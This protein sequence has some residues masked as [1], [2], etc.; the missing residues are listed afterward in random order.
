MFGAASASALLRPRRCLG[1]GAASASMF[2]HCLRLSGE[3]WA[4]LVIIVQTM[5][6][7][8][9]RHRIQ[10]YRQCLHQAQQISLGG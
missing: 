7:Q 3:D 8:M 1:L 10:Q 9:R 4:A 2:Q 6:L 5:L